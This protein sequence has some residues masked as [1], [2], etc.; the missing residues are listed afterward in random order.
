VAEDSFTSRSLLR[1]IL[2]FA[3]YQVSCAVDGLEALSLLQNETF[4]LLV[5]DLEMPRLDGFE[6]TQRVRADSRL[7]DLPV[8]LVTALDTPADR[9]RGMAAGANAYLVKSSFEQSNLLE[10]VKRLI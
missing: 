10:V 5:S 4:D 7:A 8:V 1:N 3:G 9:E 2:A 6:L